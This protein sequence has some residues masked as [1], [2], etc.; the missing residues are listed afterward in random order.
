MG[1][2]SDKRVIGRRLKPAAQDVEVKL[3]HSRCDSLHYTTMSIEH[4]YE[5]K[6]N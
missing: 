4:F 3:H 5:L 1:I 6:R 2:R